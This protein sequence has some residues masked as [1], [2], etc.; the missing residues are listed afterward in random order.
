MHY[1]IDIERYCASN[2][3]IYSNVWAAAKNL[4]NL[5]RHLTHLISQKL[6]PYKLSGNFDEGKV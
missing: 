5:H 4:Y 3:S 1:S 2:K 6:M